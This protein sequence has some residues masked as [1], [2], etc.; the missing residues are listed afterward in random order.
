LHERARAPV[1][2]QFVENFNRRRRVLVLF[3]S[4]ISF[5]SSLF[6]IFIFFFFE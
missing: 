1:R 6:F 4:W 3:V 5:I 2:V